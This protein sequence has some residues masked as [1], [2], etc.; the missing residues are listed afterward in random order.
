MF[1]VLFMQREN[2]K[3]GNDERAVE[4]HAMRKRQVFQKYGRRS[5][6]EQRLQSK[7]RNTRRYHPQ[8]HEN[9]FGEQFLVLGLKF[10]NPS[11]NTN[12]NG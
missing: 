2:N 4:H 12:R 9:K 6:T 8:K 5:R 1:V 10:F 11:Q 3:G 7:Y